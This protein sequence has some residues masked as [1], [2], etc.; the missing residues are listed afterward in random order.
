M[1]NPA[2]ESNGTGTGHAADTRFLFYSHDSYGLGHLRRTLALTAALERHVHEASSLIITGSTVAS[3]YRL[4]PRVDILKLPALTKDAHGRYRSLRLGMD[5]ADLQELRSSIALA[6][7]QSFDPSVAV[8]DKTP[9]GLRGELLPTLEWLSRTGRTKLALGVRD[10]DDSPANV[11]RDWG[12]DGLRAAITRFYDT[13]LVYG[14]RSNHDALTTMGWDDLTA[15]AHHVGYV[16]PQMPVSPAPDL[17]SDYLLVTTG[18]GADGFKLIESFALAIRDAP[19][20][21]TSVIVTGPLMADQKVRRLAELTRDLDVTLSEF[22]ADMESVI[23]GA[24][25]VVSMAGY[26]TVAELLAAHK[27]ALLVPRAHPREE[28]LVRARLLAEAGLA[29]MLHPDQLD[30]TTMR[31]A[32]ERLLGAEPPRPTGLEPSGAERAAAILASLAT[33]PSRRMVM[34]A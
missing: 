6:A 16:G 13:I 26:N 9:L 23:V 1:K 24:R 22:R 27:P 3:S 11:R 31:A 34:T 12:K 10:I 21:C 5:V 25:A 32:L 8:V 29:D 15:R 20:P 19:L 33:Q 4:P 17:P 7:A 30:A 2:A 28:Q 14:P 18:G